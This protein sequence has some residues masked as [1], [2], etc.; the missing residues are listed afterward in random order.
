MS[1][2][3]TPRQNAYL[4]KKVQKRENASNFLCLDS[5]LEAVRNCDITFAKQVNIASLY[6]NH[7]LNKF[8][9]SYISN[10]TFFENKYGFA[11]SNLSRDTVPTLVIQNNR[12]FHVSHGFYQNL[13]HGLRNENTFTFDIQVRTFKTDR[14][15]KAEMFRNP[16]LVTRLK[17][18]FSGAET[19]DAK[20]PVDVN[21]N[22]ERFSK[23]LNQDPSI[24]DAEKQRMKVAFAEGY[25]MGNNPTLRTSKAARYFKVIQQVLTV[26]IFFAIV[27]SLMASANGSVFR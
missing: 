6:E 22:N 12:N 17:N 9:I 10:N 24:S 27:I 15:V 2:I 19:T 20:T 4:N 16:S 13:L 7:F 11:E 1:A 21:S 8:K 5:F 23:L 18:L 26:V 3:L 14:S 25:L